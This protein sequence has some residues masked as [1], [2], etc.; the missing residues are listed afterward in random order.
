MLRVKD[1]GSKI[2][3]FNLYM[4]KIIEYILSLMSFSKKTRVYSK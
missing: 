2:R 3:Y 1:L 4:F